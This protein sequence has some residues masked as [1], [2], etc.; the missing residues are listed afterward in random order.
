MDID[1]DTMWD[2]FMADDPYKNHDIGR[3][4]NLGLGDETQWARA[5]LDLSVNYT[6][7]DLKK[8]FRKKV[9]LVHPDKQVNKTNPLTQQQ[10]N[11]AF[12]K[13]KHAYDF[14]LNQSNNF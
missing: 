7:N 10:A 1:D 3:N 13:I 9:L 8:N 2:E 11:D 4:N 12:R 14:L 6:C 5:E